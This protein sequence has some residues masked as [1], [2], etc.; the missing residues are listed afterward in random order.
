MIE[1][2]FAIALLAILSFLFG[3][4]FLTNIVL[5]IIIIITIIG[6]SFNMIS[7]AHCDF[8]EP[9]RE[10]AIRGVGVIFPPVGIVAGYI[11]IEDK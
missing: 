7:F 8:K 4:S 10:E 2:I 11:D 6:Y 9:Y 5:P 1:I 3:R